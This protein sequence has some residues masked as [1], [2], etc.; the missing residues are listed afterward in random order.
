MRTPEVTLKINTLNLEQRMRSERRDHQDFYF[1]A[2]LIGN[3]FPIHFSGYGC[4]IWSPESGIDVIA[5]KIENGR[6]VGIADSFCEGL[7]AVGKA[8]QKKKD[9]KIIS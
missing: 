2:K 4:I 1:F 6:Q 7:V 3:P 5:N 8:V 9:R